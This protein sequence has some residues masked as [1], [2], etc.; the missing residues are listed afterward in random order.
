MAF[1]TLR[2]KCALLAPGCLI[3][4][5]AAR[6]AAADTMNVALDPSGS[7][8]GSRVHVGVQS[9]G[10]TNHFHAG[11]S[12]TFAFTSAMAGQL[13]CF[14][15]SSSGVRGRIDDPVLELGRYL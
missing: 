11:S 3:V 12:T 13:Y 10:Y 8:V 14:A 1:R 6:T 9:G 4:L 15:A 5:G 2:W 7:T